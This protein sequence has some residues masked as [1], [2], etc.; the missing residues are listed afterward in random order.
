MTEYD[1][2]SMFSKLTVAENGLSESDIMF[3]NHMSFLFERLKSRVKPEKEQDMYRKLSIFLLET[4]FDDMSTKYAK[5][6]KL[7]YFIL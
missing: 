1:L 6:D 2:V 4:L 5:A 3:I 7:E